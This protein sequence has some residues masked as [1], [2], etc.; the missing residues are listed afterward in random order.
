MFRPYFS[1]LRRLVV[2]LLAITLGLLAAGTALAV[3]PLPHTIYGQLR[4]NST[5]AANGSA[6][7]ILVHGVSFMTTT[8]TIE[9]VPGKY[10]YNVPGDDDST[11]GVVEGG[12]NGDPITFAYPGY[13]LAQ[14]IPWAS[15]AVNALD[16]ANDPFTYTWSVNITGSTPFTLT[17][18]DGRPALVINANGLDLGQTTIKLRANQNCTLNPSTTVRRCFEINP[19]NATG[20]NATLTFFFYSSQVP[21]GMLC[22]NIDAYR[23]S[24]GWVQLNRDSSYG[25]LGRECVGDPRSL[26]VS[27]VSSFSSFVLQD[28]SPTAVSLVRFSAHSPASSIPSWMLPALGLAVL[29]LGAALLGQ[30]RLHGKPGQTSIR[31]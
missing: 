28:S 12:V 13:E 20:R 1:M 30:F 31:G 10:H 5:P 6:L 29:T 19:A 22:T 23:F 25:S 21:T 18:R 15:G 4:L 9:G 11:A 8:S 2:L 17:A 3:P 16:V 14:T 7:T 27:G 24:G 26:R